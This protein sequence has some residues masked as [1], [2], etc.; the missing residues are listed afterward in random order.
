MKTLYQILVSS[1]SSL[2]RLVLRIYG[3]LSINDDNFKGKLLNFQPLIKRLSVCLASGDSD[4]VYWSLV[5][6]HDL[7]MMGKSY[8]DAF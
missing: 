2:Q 4:L 5:L 8:L 6:V 1:E 7:A 3:F